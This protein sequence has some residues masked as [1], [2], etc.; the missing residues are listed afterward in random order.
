M[1]KYIVCLGDGMADEPIASIGNKTPL[2]AA[3]TP[4][5]DYFSELGCNGLV[6]TVPG[7]FPPGSDVANMGILG[8]NPELYYTG[9]API[10]AASL[11]LTLQPTQI[12]F[13]CNLVS[14]QNGVMT[15]FTSD[16]ISTEDATELIQY[17]NT[18]FANEN[19]TFYPGVSY[20]HIAVLEDTYNHLS[21]TPPH[22]ITDKPVADFLPKGDEQDFVRYLME[23]SAEYLKDHPINVRRR[24]EGRHATTHIW[25]WSQGKMPQLPSFKSQFGVTGGIVTAVDLLKGLGKLSGLETPFVEGATGFI[26]TNYKGKIE[27]SFSIL[28][29]HDFVYIH[30]E[31]PDEAGHLGD[32]DIKIKAI[33]DFDTHVMGPVREY[34]A[35]H[36]D[37]RVLI[38][39]DHPTP[40][41]IKTHTSSPVPFVL[42][43]KTM[44]KDAVRHYDEA[45]AAEGSLSFSTPWDLMHQFV[46]K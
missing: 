5:M 19:I 46:S 17:L 30:I 21:T 41:A 20:R 36:D 31:A 22:D 40:C 11:G 44:E 24:A 15:S 33:E 39:P 38:L 32:V 26:D 27:A 13:R 29:R 16:H 12:A 4:N 7:P 1:T 10:E 18:C 3:R 43:S 6:H 8:Y 37:V 28:D 42:Y 35:T 23:K 45:S 2:Q 14:I 9:R 34:V 25:L